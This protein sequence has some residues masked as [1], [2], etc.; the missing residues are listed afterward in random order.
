MLLNHWLTFNKFKAVE[1]RQHL[2]TKIDGM[3]MIVPLFEQA[4]G[5]EQGKV[6]ADSEI[7]AVFA[8]WVEA[9]PQEKR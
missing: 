3:A 4:G 7:D 6:V 5:L 9:A 8:K 1:L 2:K